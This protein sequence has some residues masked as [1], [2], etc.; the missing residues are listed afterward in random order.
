MRGR[1]A[2]GRRTS[3][4][5]TR[6]PPTRTP[7][8]VVES[9]EALDFLVV[10]EIFL[11]RDRAAGPRRAAGRRLRREGRD[12]RQRRPAGAARPQG[13]RAARRAA[14][15]TW[16]SSASWPSGWATRCRARRPREI[17]DEIAALV[18]ILAGISYE[19]LERESLVWPCLDRSDTRRA[20]IV[21]NELPARPRHLPGPRRQ[22]AD[23]AG[24][25]RLP[26]DPDHRPP[27]GA[28]LLRLDDPAHARAAGPGAGRAAGDQPAGRRADCTSKKAAWSRSPAAAAGSPCPRA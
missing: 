16:R 21:R 17:M 14:R 10:N 19:R 5:T 7:H 3:S 27:P 11:T 20:A 23:G 25:R 1:S 8:R 18:P 24:R 2:C 26:A 12:V 13:G 4:A 22:R 6:P 28:L 9:L 15:P